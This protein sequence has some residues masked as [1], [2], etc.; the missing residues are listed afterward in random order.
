[1]LTMN[2]IQSPTIYVIGAGGTGGF[3]FTH[4]ARLLAG[5]QIPIHLFDGDTIEPK[6]LKRQQFGKEQVGQNKAQALADW[7]KATILDAPPITVHP[8]YVVD[9]ERLLATLFMETEDDGVPI[10]ISAVDNVATRKTI[11]EALEMLPGHIAIDSGN[12]AQG[13]QVV[14]TTRQD[15]FNQDQAFGQKHSV[16]LQNMFEVYPELN[17]VEDLNP[18]IETSCDAVVESQ[19]Q[20]MMANVRNA[21]IIANLVMAFLNHQPLAG[22]VYTSQLNDFLTHVRTAIH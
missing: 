20:A 2:P 7:A 15:V 10:V 8:H 4:L 13:G 11:N 17:A 12:N 21:D 1:M 5:T 9:A 14:W 3:T 22:N 6:N 19:P 18:G 16:R